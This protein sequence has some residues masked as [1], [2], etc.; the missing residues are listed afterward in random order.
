VLYID[1]AEVEQAQRLAG[2]IPT[3]EKEYMDVRLLSSAVYPCLFALEY[4][5]SHYDVFI[6]IPPLLTF[7]TRLFS[8]YN[9]P[10]WVLKSDEM[11]TV[12]REG[13]YLISV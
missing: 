6:F 13:N 1:S 7:L 10:N 4:G 2:Y 9:I 5:L 12:F 3:T 11:K 8:D